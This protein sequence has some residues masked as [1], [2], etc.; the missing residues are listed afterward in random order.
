MLSD[1][2]REIL[3]LY[4]TYTNREHF[5]GA[6]GSK[7]LLPEEVGALVQSGLP[8]WVLVELRE[9]LSENPAEEG[10][11]LWIVGESRSKGKL[12]RVTHDSPYE[13]FE[14]A[15]VDA[16]YIAKSTGREGGETLVVTIPKGEVL[17]DSR[18]P[19]AWS[20][21]DQE[22]LQILEDLDPYYD[23][24][25][26]ETEEEPYEPE[27]DLWDLSD[28]YKRGEGSHIEEECSGPEE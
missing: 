3:K 27:G 25:I 4:K 16:A 1:N 17:W 13:A 8:A 19:T 23:E 26:F 22:T 12:F 7:T 9:R 5:L 24:D 28:Y 2:V 11:P 18:S 14:D 21:L 10:E 15:L 20:E 6:L